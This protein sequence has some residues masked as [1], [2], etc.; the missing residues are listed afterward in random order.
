[1]RK[2][3]LRDMD[4]FYK[5]TLKKMKKEHIKN[6]DGFF[7]DYIK[8]IHS[9][10][11]R[12]VDHVNFNS[13]V[14]LF[15]NYK[16]LNNVKYHYEQFTLTNWNTSTNKQID[17]VINKKVLQGLKEKLKRHNTVATVYFNKDINI[18]G[19]DF[20]HDFMHVIE[21]DDVCFY[22]TYDD[23]DKVVRDKDTGYEESAGRTY[24]FTIWVI[25]EVPE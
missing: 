18:R 7:S 16:N 22:V 1:M 13:K 21:N 10:L 9:S 6:D 14:E 20:K 17:N 23:I 11:K 2:V 15:D 8:K 24:Q 19:M 4:D 3:K 25:Y 5:K 12:Q